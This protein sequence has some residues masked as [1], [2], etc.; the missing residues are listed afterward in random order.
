MATLLDYL[1]RENHWNGIFFLECSIEG[2][3]VTMTEDHRLTSISERSRMLE[4]GNQLG[5]GETR[6]C[7]MCCGYQVFRLRLNSMNKCIWAITGMNIARALGDKFLKQEDSRFS[8]TP[9]VSE[10][11]EISQESRALAV[12]ARYFTWSHVVH[13]SHFYTF[14]I[15]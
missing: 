5:E 1:L 12:M 6:L 13:I 3:S 11:L 10:V 7:G 8:S 9:F 2:R 14:P 4:M 15:Q